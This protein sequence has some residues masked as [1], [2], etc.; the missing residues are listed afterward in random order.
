M[1]GMDLKFI[2]MI[3]R[4]LLGPLSTF[5]LMAGTFLTHSYSK[6]SK[7]RGTPPLTAN[8]PHHPF[9]PFPHPYNVLFV[10]LQ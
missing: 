5:G 3:L 1:E 6:Q 9:H 2:P 7:Q 10:I 4:C 8:P